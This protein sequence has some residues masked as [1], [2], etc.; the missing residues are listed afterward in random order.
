MRLW[1]LV[2]L[3]G[4]GVFAG[5]AIGQEQV[6]ASLPFLGGQTAG[7]NA[8]DYPGTSDRDLWVVEDFAISTDV[9]LGR[10][11]S[12]G[13]VFPAPLQLTDVNA[14]VYDALP[15]VGNLIMSSL[16]GHGA[17]DG[18]G[19]FS[20]T[21]GGQRLAAGSYYIVWDVST[22]GTQIAI[23]WAQGGPN[24]V[25]GG[26]PNNAWLWNPGGGW[27]YP[28]NIKPVP[29]DLQGTGQTGVNYTIY[30]VPVPCYANCDHSTEAPILNVNDFQCFINAFATGSVYANCDSSTAAPTLNVNDFQCFLN[31]FAMGC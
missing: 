13:T 8:T 10:F 25:G 6:V 20:T 30:G 29:Q 5:V 16:P 22:I 31:Q 4:A 18:S 11:E 23:M 27:G 7:P 1:M 19:R 12:L 14:R 17:V 15:T 26:L 28:N 9:M 21:F 2:S 3:A 24:A